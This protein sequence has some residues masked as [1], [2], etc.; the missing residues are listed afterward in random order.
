VLLVLGYRDEDARR[1]EQLRDLEAVGAG[2]HVDRVTTELGG[3]PQGEARE[4]VEQLLSRRGVVLRAR[5]GK[6]CP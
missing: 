4:L 6:D 3:V 2:S 1:N 5:H